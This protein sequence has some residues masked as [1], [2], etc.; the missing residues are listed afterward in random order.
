VA[1]GTSFTHRAADIGWTHLASLV[2][3]RKKRR[4]GGFLRHLSSP[5]HENHGEFIWVWV[6]TYRYIFSG[7][8]IHLPAILGFTRYQ[9]FDPSPYEFMGSIHNSMSMTMFFLLVWICLNYVIDIHVPCF[10]TDYVWSAQ[11]GR[12]C[13]CSC[14]ICLVLWNMDLLWTSLFYDYPTC[15][16]H[17]LFGWCTWVAAT[18]LFVHCLYANPCFFPA[19]LLHRWSLPHVSVYFSNHIPLMLHTPK[20]SLVFFLNLSWPS[21][22][23][24]DYWRW[25][26]Q[27]LVFRSHEKPHETPILKPWP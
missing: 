22:Q 4:L 16:I 2:P 27:I 14:C 1:Q 20:R 12:M 23:S 5:K 18:T 13:L 8:N 9:G 21:A 7:M 25:H 19:N 26:V 10:W 24:W 17:V 11:S 3:W 6:N 15:M